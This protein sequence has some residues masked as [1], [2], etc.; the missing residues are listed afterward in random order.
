MRGEHLSLW[1]ANWVLRIAI[2][3][4][5]QN[6]G[7][8]FLCT[9]SY[10]INVTRTRP[11]FDRDISPMITCLPLRLHCLR[12]PQG[13][14][15]VC[16]RYPQGL[17]L[18]SRYA[19]VRLR[20]VEINWNTREW[21]TRCEIGCF[22]MWAVA[23]SIVLYYCCSWCVRDFTSAP[24]AAIVAYTMSCHLQATM[25][26]DRMFWIRGAL[27][28]PVKSRTHSPQRDSENA[29]LTSLYKVS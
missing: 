9:G 1:T 12:G 2:L 15:G 19:S 22:G 14:V 13:L 4:W 26:Y 6:G 10:I 5:W 21:T 29:S 25:K 3:D 20:R 8:P 7:F 28:I 23:M 16:M 11:F 18:R 27:E 24:R 17:V